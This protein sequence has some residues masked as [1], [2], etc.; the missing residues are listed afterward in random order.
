MPLG[1]MNNIFTYINM[2]GKQQFA[3]LQMMTLEQVADLFGVS[4][5]WVRDHAT[6]RRPHIPCVRLGGKRALLRFRPQDIQHFIK[7]HLEHTE[8]SMI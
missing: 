1:C 5:A 2:N 3:E 7:L 6:R 8:G 4:K